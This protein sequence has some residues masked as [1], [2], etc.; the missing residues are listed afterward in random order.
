M[1]GS[2]QQGS[3]WAERDV[4]PKNMDRSKTCEDEK[5]SRAAAGAHRDRGHLFLMFLLRLAGG[6]RLSFVY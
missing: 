6:T 3:G 1:P 2:G 5:C 4:R